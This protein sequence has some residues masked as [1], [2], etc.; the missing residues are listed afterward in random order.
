[1]DNRGVG[2]SDTPWGLYSTSEMAKEVLELLDMVGWTQ[3]GSLHAVGVSMGGMIAQELALLIPERIVSLTLISST[4]GNKPAAPLTGLLMFA[5][6]FFVRDTQSMMKIVIAGLYPEHYLEAPDVKGSDGKNRD[7]LE[8]DF[9][10]RYGVTRRQSLSG[11]VFQTAAAI[12]H[13]VSPEKLLELDRDLS[14]I[15]IITGDLDGIVNPQRSRDLHG[16]LPHSEF[17]LFEGGGHAL[18]SQYSD[19]L[20]T[21]I[22]R[23]IEEGKQRLSSREK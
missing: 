5:K 3:Q 11:R 1:M 15:A 16:F 22:E 2:N 12:G 6:L 8:K 19:R 7:R 14:K 18:P 9:I 10:Y 23:I 13:R 20:N 4:A 21:T 17:I